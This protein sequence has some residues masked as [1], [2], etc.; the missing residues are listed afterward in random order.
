MPKARLASS[1]GASFLGGLGACSPRKILKSG[2]HRMHFQHSGAK[3]RVFEQNTD[4]IK[5]WL[6]YSAN[7]FLFIYFFLPIVLNHLFQYVF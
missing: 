3:I 5:F 6:F 1:E 4:V 2:P 7:I